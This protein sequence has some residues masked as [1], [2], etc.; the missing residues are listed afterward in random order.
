MGSSGSAIGIISCIGAS[1]GCA[2]A[3][4]QAGVRTRTGASRGLWPGGR[5]GSALWRAARLR[6]PDRLAGSSWGGEVG[7][8]EGGLGALGPLGALL[9][10]A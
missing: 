6:L 2:E 10:H 8:R 3:G 1:R 7:D 9:M 5:L 4:G